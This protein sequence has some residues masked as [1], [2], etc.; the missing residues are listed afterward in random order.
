MKSHQVRVS[1]TEYTKQL[2]NSYN[3]ISLGGELRIQRIFRA[4]YLILILSCFLLARN[5]PPYREVLG[6]AI[7]LIGIF[8]LTSSIRSRIK[9]N[10]FK[11]TKQPFEQMLYQITE[12]TEFDFAYPPDAL[13]ITLYKKE[14]T[15]RLLDFTFN[16]LTAYQ[17]LG[18]GFLISNQ[19]GIDFIIPEGLFETEKF[20]ELHKSSSGQFKNKK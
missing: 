4:V 10:Q 2:E 17:W 12:I 3:Q 1:A 14:G 19:D 20:D 5:F 11:K 8:L 6:A 13:R 7:L 16:E 18:G 15:E 9:Q